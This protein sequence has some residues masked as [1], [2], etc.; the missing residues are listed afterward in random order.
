[1]KNYIFFVILLT[2]F[3]CSLQK[4]VQINV[5]TDR[6]IYTKNNDTILVKRDS[7]YTEFQT[8][9]YT[10]EYEK[11]NLKENR[12]AIVRAVEYKID[13]SPKTSKLI[14][15]DGGMIN[16]LKN[17]LSEENY[18][19]FERRIP[20]TLNVIFSLKDSTVSEY[21]VSIYTKNISGFNLTNKE[22]IELFDYC[23]KIQFVY[24]GNEYQNEEVPFGYKF[25][26]LK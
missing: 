6:S 2:S 3:S 22:I 24:N 15:E 26:S 16:V 18:S 21:K 12:S 1:M 11:F 13:L 10:L 5:V 4:N 14:E 23:K 7:I 20:L 17:I 8:K 25:V 9:N 19:K